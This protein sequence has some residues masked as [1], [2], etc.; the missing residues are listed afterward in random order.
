MLLILC[1]LFILILIFSIITYP[2][3]IILIIFSTLIFI[4]II[5]LIGKNLIFRPKLSS[6]IYNVTE[7]G[8]NYRIYQKNS[9]ITLF[10]S[11][12]NYGNIDILQNP[13]ESLPYNVCVYDYV[14]YGASVQTFGGIYTMTDKHLVASGRSVLKDLEKKVY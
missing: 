5:F 11:H 6:N 1:L 4:L 13:F 7:T 14:N 10:V 8:I 9:P 12:G 3:V 2:S